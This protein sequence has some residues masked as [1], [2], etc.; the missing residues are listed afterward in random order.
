MN[1]ALYAFVSTQ[2]LFL[3]IGAVVVADESTISISQE[4]GKFVVTVRDQ[5]FCEVDYRSYPKPVVY[6]IYGPG[7]VPMTRNHPMVAGVAG[8]A[9]DHPHHKSMWFGHGDINGVSFWDEKGKTIT[10]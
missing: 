3:S 10:D 5:P 7:Q 2:L 1:R 8:E 9:A 6:P 4:A